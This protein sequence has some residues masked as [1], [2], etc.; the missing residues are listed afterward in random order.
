M[1]KGFHRKLDLEAKKIS[2]AERKFDR[3]DR[4]KK[5]SKSL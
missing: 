5:V 3:G 2:L 4:W 1:A